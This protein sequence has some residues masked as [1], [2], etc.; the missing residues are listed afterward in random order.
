MAR[1]HYTIQECFETLAAVS[2]KELTALLDR[3][4]F[5]LRVTTS[6]RW[7]PVAPR[8]AP[9]A[10]AGAMIRMRRPSLPIAQLSRAVPR[11]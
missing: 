11:R 1:E 7:A 10:T 4:D 8:L 5:V 6:P 3:P 2:A 9:S